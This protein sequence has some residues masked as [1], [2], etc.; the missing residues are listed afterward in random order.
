LE[1]QQRNLSQPKTPT[2]KGVIEFAAC[3]G[4]KKKT[5]TKIEGIWRIVVTY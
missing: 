3:N 2:R 4:P 1:L 5:R